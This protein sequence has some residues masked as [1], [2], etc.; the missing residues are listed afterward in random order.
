[1]GGTTELKGP[2]LAKGV[3]FSD[4][5]HEVPLLGHADGEGVVVVRI[6]DDVHAI[7]ASCTHYGGPLAEGLVVDGTIRCPWHHA[8]FD[9][10]SGEAIAAPALADVPCWKVERSGDLVVIRTKREASARRMPAVVPSSVVLVGAG[11]AGAACAETLRK[12]G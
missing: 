6:G 5:S 2:D 7:G 10:R 1:M 12:E 9:L 4:L 3:A 8:C 11:A